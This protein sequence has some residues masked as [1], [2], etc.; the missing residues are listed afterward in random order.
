MSV[1]LVAALATGFVLLARDVPLDAAP[2]VEG[3][4]RAADTLATIETVDPKARQVL[5]KLP[6]STL[7]TLQVGPQ[8]KNLDQLKPGDHVLAKYVEAKVVHL[9]KSA[10]KPTPVAK[11]TIGVAPPPGAE[12]K[13]V[14]TIVGIDPA[15]GTVA[16]SGSDNQAETLT[17][18]ESEK[19]DVKDLK[20]GD[21]VE[22]TYTKGV[23][24]SLDPVRS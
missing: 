3:V 11:V 14:T 18:P 4:I 15:R 8:V 23:A 10:E 6:D 13:A 17:V 19:A 9:K 5:V 21:N 7:V 1:R 16:L 24:I 20:V 2:E 22:V 12:V